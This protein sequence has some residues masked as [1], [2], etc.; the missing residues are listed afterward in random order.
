[1]K[2][3]GEDVFL[4]AVPHAR[5][6]LL[7]LLIRHIQATSPYTDNLFQ[8]RQLALTCNQSHNPAKSLWIWLDNS[9][10]GLQIR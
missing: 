7:R 5:R 8:A 1:M 2:I 10:F 9:P 6:D 4:N 3:E